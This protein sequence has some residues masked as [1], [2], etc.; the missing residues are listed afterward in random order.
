MFAYTTFAITPTIGTVK[1][2]TAR[3]EEAPEW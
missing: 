2:M 1:L 3:L